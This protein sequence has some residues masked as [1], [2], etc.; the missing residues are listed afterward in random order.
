MFNDLKNIIHHIVITA[1]SATIALSLP[2]TGKFI[3]DNYLIYWARIESEKVFLISMEIAVAV[4]L[5][6]FFNFLDRSWK[7]RKFSNMA[8]KDMGLVLV[9]HPE[10]LR[11]KKRAQKLKDQ[12]GH[13]KDAMII[14]S[15]GGNTFVNPEGDLHRVLQNCREAK[16]ILLNP[17]S[18]GAFARAKCIPDPDVTLEHFK[19]QL[20]KSIAFLKSLNSPQKIIRLKLYEETPLFKLAVLG[21]Y[22]F[23][24]YYHADVHIKEMPEYIFRHSP[25]HGNL[26]HAFYQ[27]FLSKW[28]DSS[29]PE[30]DFETDELVRRDAAGKEITREK[31][32]EMTFPS[33]CCT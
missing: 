24:K 7:D 11:T 28:R 25:D 29:L 4:L 27:I 1:L 12:H 3:A 31:F 20:T 22:I 10:N 2:Y 6:I 5:I 8:Q 18:E 26:F 21:D 19:E 33:S 30:Y 14:G 15:T 9:A 17:F 16:I 23:M 32:S 13:A